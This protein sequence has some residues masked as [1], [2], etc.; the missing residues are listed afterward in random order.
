MVS[1]TAIVSSFI[2]KV[3]LENFIT[4]TPCPSPVPTLILLVVTFL[5]I[6][7]MLGI[8]VCILSLLTHTCIAIFVTPLTPITSSTGSWQQWQGSGLPTSYPCRNVVQ[9]IQHCCVGW[10]LT[11][12]TPSTNKH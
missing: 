4:S 10:T 1:L 9:E 7:C 2:F 12:D 8:P 11:P 3:Q 6:S 5:F